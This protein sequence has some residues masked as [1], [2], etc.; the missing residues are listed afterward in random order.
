VACSGFGLGR[1]TDQIGPEFGCQLFVAIQL[2]LFGDSQRVVMAHRIFVDSIGLIYGEPAHSLGALAHS[3]RPHFIFLR[4]QYTH[5]CMSIHT[6]KY[7][8]VYLY[9]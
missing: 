5:I 2:F 7:I 3:T 1:F 6:Y 9:E 4:T 8:H